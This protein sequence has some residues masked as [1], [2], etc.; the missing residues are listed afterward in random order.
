MLIEFQV[1][2]FRS[3]RDPQTFSMVAS[4]FADHETNTFDP[5][6]AGFGRFLRSAGIYGANAA[7]KTN[8]L[9][10][11]QFVQGLVVGSA[12]A[13]PGQTLP[14]QPFKLSRD[15]RNAPSTFQVT[16]VQ[17]GVRYEYGFSLDATKIREEWLMEYVN[18]RGRAIF[19]RKYDERKKTYDWRFSS[20]LKGQ[21][22]VWR[23]ATRP[24]V[25]FLSRA[26]QLNSVQLLPVF[27]WFQK[28]LVVV[29]G[30][31]T[32]NPILTLQL[33][34]KPE[35][36]E[37][38]LP[39]LKEA[40]LGISDIEVKRERIPQ[41]AAPMVVVGSGFLE[42]GPTG[43]P[44]NVVRLTV[45]HGQ[46][47]EAVG[48]D[49]SEESQGTQALFRTAGAWLNVLSNGEI[50]FIDEIDTSL[51]P[52]LVQFLIGKFHSNDANPKNAQLI[53]TTHDTSLLDQ[54]MFRRDQF[55][56]VEKDRDGS[57]RLYPLTDFRPRNDESLERWY[58][59]GKYG[60]LPNLGERP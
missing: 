31:T 28:R 7:G 32:M 8:L 19:E 16:L 10:A 30:I 60:A 25:L 36:T 5:K 23:D 11:L 26:T 3:F 59:R 55:W 21:R 57:S 44:E 18:P 42:H 4:N 39:F 22:S 34:N 58:M 48:F 1:G 46:G 56:F 12:S 17:N 45:S 20:F 13:A 35:G 47:K 29:V 52:K 54:E 49:I 6:L 41:G 15:T 14:H 37:K 51:H 2:N 27:E 50:L 40:D 43:A 24:E 53:F 38:L 9:R 33:L